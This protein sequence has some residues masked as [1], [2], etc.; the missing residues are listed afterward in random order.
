MSR[1][2]K[3]NKEIFGEGFSIKTFHQKTGI[4]DQF[5]G[6]SDREVI[7]YVMCR[8]CGWKYRRLE[9]IVKLSNPTI[10]FL[11]ENAE[12]KRRNDEKAK[13]FFKKR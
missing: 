7:C 12:N 4:G 8:L 1:E 13:S 5:S 3:E 10:R 2:D 9:K 6:L 11:T